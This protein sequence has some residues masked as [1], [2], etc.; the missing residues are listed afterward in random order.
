MTDL[1]QRVEAEGG[2]LRD[3]R[4]SDSSDRAADIGPPDEVARAP[5]L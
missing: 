3:D 2:E 1:R 5:W 4:K